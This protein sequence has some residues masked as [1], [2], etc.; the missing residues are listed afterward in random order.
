[1][2]AV[3]TD[4]R[5]DT[6]GN[7]A[8]FLRRHQMTGKMDYLIGSPAELRPVWKRWRIASRRGKHGLVA[9]SSLVYGVSP[10][11]KIVTIYPAN[12]TPSDIV[13]DVPLLARL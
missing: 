12:F 9:H 2:L 10:R 11:G 3:S 6:P 7:V 1:M 8:T 5:G 4:P 13:H